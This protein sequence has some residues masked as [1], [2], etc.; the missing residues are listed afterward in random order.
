VYP[1]DARS[2][3]LVGTVKVSLLLDERG[4]IVEVQSVEG[5]VLLQNAAKDAALK[6]RFEPYQVNGRSVPVAGYLTFNFSL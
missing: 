5:P 2:R 3:G 6:W 1:P 4:E